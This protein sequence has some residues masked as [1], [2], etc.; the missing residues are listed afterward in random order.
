MKLKRAISIFV[1]IL[2]I[3]VGIL[4]NFS[5]YFIQMQDRTSSGRWHD[6]MQDKASYFIQFL[7]TLILPLGIYALICELKR[8]Q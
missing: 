7:L 1:S 8:K 2:T 4:L 5:F 3:L 6:I